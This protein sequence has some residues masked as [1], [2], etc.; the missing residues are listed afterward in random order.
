MARP[1]DAMEQGADEPGAMACALQRCSFKPDGQ[2]SATTGKNK[3]RAFE[4]SLEMMSLERFNEI[5]RR[6]PTMFI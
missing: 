4:D 5:C 6:P 2:E 1:G 3:R